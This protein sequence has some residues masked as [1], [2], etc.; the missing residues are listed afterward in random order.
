MY[1]Y[2]LYREH[3]SDG[4]ESH[5]LNSSPFTL[6]QTTYPSWKATKES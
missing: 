3:C 5:T 1:I 4:E 6:K 2:I